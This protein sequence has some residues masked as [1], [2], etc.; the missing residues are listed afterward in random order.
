MVAPDQWYNI[1][2]SSRSLLFGGSQYLGS[3]WRVWF[4]PT[5]CRISTW[6]ASW[7]AIGHRIW[8]DVII[9]TSCKFGVSFNVSTVV[10]YMSANFDSI[11]E[12]HWLLWLPVMM[13][14]SWNDND[15]KKWLLSHSVLCVTLRLS[16]N[17]SVVVKGLYLVR[18]R[19]SDFHIHV[20]CIFLK[21]WM[22]NAQWF[23]PELCT[24]SRCEQTLKVLR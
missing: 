2:V 16:A 15:S 17:V 10:D 20:R 9:L 6:A 12:W 14:Y 23:N 7:L 24:I 13:Q 11:C 5:V 8:C 22:L 1:S 3:A 19:S 21:P 4:L 18:V